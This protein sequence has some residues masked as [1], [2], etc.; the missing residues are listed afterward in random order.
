MSNPRIGCSSM[1]VLYLC[2]LIVAMRGLRSESED[3]SAKLRSKVC[4]GQSLGCPDRH[5]AHNINIM[6]TY[7][8]CCFEAQ[9]QKPFFVLMQVIRQIA[10]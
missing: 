3:C 9:A 2:P 6:Y 1:H 8:F 5:F 7:L 10:R 4:T